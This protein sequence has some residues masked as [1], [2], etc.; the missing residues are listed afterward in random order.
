MPRLP[1][2][3]SR[4]AA[5]LALGLA[6][7][8]PL[9]GQPRLLIFSKTLDYRHAVIPQ[10]ITAITM[11]GQANGFAVD[12]TEDSRKF[13]ASNLGRYQAVF[14]NQVDGDVF[15]TAQQNAFQAYIRKGGG[16]AGLHAASYTELQW[17][18]FG[19]LLGAYFK[20]HSPVTSGRLAVEDRN[21]PSTAALPAQWMRSEEW[22]NFTVN[23]R[24]AVKVLITVDEKT[25]AGGNMGADHPI[26]WYHDFDGGRSWYSAL[27]HTP[28]SFTDANFLAHLQGGIAYAMGKAATSIR[29]G[30]LFP[31]AFPQTSAGNGLRI[32]TL[33]P[34]HGVRSGHAGRPGRFEFILAGRPGAAYSAQGALIPMARGLP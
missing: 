32:S 2:R 8:S 17:P 27:G 30:H 7:A 16:F 34:C 23:P 28:E 13:T 14:F 29:P 3:F 5:L 1:A 9:M 31:R 21:H 12:T 4:P 20:D 15:D 10:A 25:Y 18:W 11:M 6:C 19:Q 24:P 26:V 22:Y 33:V